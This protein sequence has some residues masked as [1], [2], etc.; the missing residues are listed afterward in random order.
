L[1][2]R[3]ASRFF[4]ACLLFLAQAVLFVHSVEHSFGL[5]DAGGHEETSCPICIAGHGMGA[6]LP[7]Q[8]IVWVPDVAAF[9]SPQG[10]ASEAQDA[11]SILPHQRG[12]PQYT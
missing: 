7:G 9:C 4:L 5:A 8:A 6:A 3:C 1:T 10:G 11:A 2:S 12:P